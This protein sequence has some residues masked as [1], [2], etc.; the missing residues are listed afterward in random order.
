MININPRI[1]IPESELS[2]TF[3]RSSGAG[4][5]NVNKV[6][7][8]VTLSFD[9]DGSTA[10]GSREKG[11]IRRRLGNRI[12]GEGVLMISASEHRSQ[13]ANREAVRERFVQLLKEALHTARPRKKTRVPRAERRRRIEG[14]KHRARLKSGR[15]RVK[16]NGE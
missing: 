14:K 11:L 16:M 7:T 5:Q 4:G 1:I 12:S 9:L 8:R 2:F 3:S 6:N 13:W 15:G 10:L